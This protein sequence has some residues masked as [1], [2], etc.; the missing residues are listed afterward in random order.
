MPTHCSGKTHKGI[1][2]RL[3]VT[4][5][6]KVIRKK[7]GK[8]HL[9]S[10]KSGKRLRRLRRSATVPDHLTKRIKMQLIK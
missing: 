3:K 6:G 5:T 8:S 7:G 4:G 9:L 2:K 1:A 10:N